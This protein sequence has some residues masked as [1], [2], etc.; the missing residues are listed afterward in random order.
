MV[1]HVYGVACTYAECPLIKASLA[2]LAVLVLEEDYQ[3]LE[4]ALR[5]AVEPQRRDEV[6]TLLSNLS[7][8][9]IVLRS[10]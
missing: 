3:A 6:A 5:I 8:G 4:I 2:G 1:R 9:R 7:S 10:L